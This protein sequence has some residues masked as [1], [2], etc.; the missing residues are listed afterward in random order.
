M[1]YKKLYYNIN[2]TTTKKALPYRQLYVSNAE[3][4]METEN[5]HL[6]D[7]TVIT[8]KCKYHQW[9]LKLVGKISGYI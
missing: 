7:P 2:W 6:A 3:R 4:K 8:V 9:I 1:Y 5:H